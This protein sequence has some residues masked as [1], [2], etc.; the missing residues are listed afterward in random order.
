MVADMTAKVPRST[1]ATPKSRLPRARV[2][3]SATA[4]PTTTPSGHDPR[5]L[6]HHHAA[7]LAGAGAQ[8]H[9]HADL[10]RALGDD[11]GEHAVEADGAENE[12]QRRGDG[13]RQQ[14]ERELHH[15][16][17]RQLGHGEDAVDRRLGGD[18][19]DELAHLGGERF[20]ARRLDDVGRRGEPPTVGA[21][22]RRAA[23]RRAPAGR[24]GSCPAARLRRRRPPS[25]DV[26]R[27][28]RAGAG[29][30][31]PRPARSARRASG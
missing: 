1:A 9:P 3:T 23:G 4:T 22:A 27:S 5:P 26:A 15:R 24:R 12:R 6:P 17:A 31:D 2:V 13:E 19:A 20:G 28:R 14:G 7:H 8:S 21:S 16:V 10:A 29:R 18:L 25:R 11:V 30:A